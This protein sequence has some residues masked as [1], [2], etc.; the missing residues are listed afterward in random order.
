MLHSPLRL[1]CDLTIHLPFEVPK[2]D[3]HQEMCQRERWASKGGGLGYP[4]SI[5]EGNEFQR[6]CWASKGDVL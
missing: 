4:T 2:G 1:M 6:V 5:G 3:G